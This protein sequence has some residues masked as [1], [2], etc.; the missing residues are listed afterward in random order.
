[1]QSLMR[2]VTVRVAGRGIQQCQHQQ[3]LYSSMYSEVAFSTSASAVS[4]PPS[5][6]DV[7]SLRQQL[8]MF[9]EY[10]TAQEFLAAGSFAKAL[11]ALQRVGEVL[12]STMGAS[13]PLA[14]LVARETARTLQLQGRYEEADNLLQGCLRLQ[15][16]TPSQDEHTSVVLLHH[17]THNHM[18]RGDFAAAESS[19]DEAVAICEKEVGPAG[20]PA[21]PLSLM[22]TSYHMRGLGALQMQEW[23]D[24]EEHLQLA[25]RWSQHSAAAQ[26]VALHNLGHLH[27]NSA[28]CPDDYGDNDSTIESD[29]STDNPNPAE[30]RSAIL[31]QGA[32]WNRDRNKNKN[33]KSNGEKRVGTGLDLDEEQTA[34]V[35]E[36][37]GC[38]EEAIEAASSEDNASSGDSAAA[39]MCGPMGVAPEFAPGA[40]MLGPGMEGDARVVPSSPAPAKAGEGQPSSSDPEPNPVLKSLK[41]SRLRSADELLMNRLQ[42]P[43]FAVW[44]ASTLCSAAGAYVALG[45]PDRASELRSSALQALEPHKQTPAAQPA[46]GWVLGLMAYDSMASSQAVTA[47]GLFRAADDH[48]KGPFALHSHR[49]QYERGYLQGG[50]GV[51]LS[52][53]DK[54]EGD[55][56]KATGMSHE[57]LA[58]H[59][60]W[61]TSSPVPPHYL[62]PYLE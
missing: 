37:L 47:E 56:E 57:L 21:V 43:Q 12:S 51:L 15:H 45:E 22:G 13:S 28:L 50:Y 62:F 49:W 17:I 9:P 29:S 32:L 31:A 36:A 3:R 40:S 10:S 18:M 23:D 2:R 48:L 53:W 35:R 38:W 5:N 54:R 11:P 44:Y 30:A 61:G 59:K 39:A 26:L 20:T 7:Q 33:N 8:S 25:A 34:A 60:Q 16:A 1:M 4:A 42:S 14:A 27:W 6:T 55:S 58:Q 41:K 52:K 24:A 19:A 46:L